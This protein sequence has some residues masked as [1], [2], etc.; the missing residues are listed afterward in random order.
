LAVVVVV[1]VLEALAFSSKELAVQTV[2]QTLRSIAAIVA[3]YVALVVGSTL[4]QETLLGGVTF[5]NSST[6]VLL[7]AGIL[8]PLAAVLGGVVTATIAGRAPY[9][10]IAPACLEVALETTYLFT[11]HKVDGPLWFEGSAGLSLV[12][13]FVIGAWLWTATT[14]RRPSAVFSG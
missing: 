13:G 10:H 7:I 6:Q 5:Q 2:V 11:T 12:A 8:T 4:V 1:C 14:R 3:G 9:W